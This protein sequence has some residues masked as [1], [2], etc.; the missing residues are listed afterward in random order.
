MLS[1]NTTKFK[2][3]ILY[4]SFCYNLLDINGMHL[5]CHLDCSRKLNFEK[6]IFS[7]KYLHL[8]N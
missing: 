3:Y 8:D 7:K 6:N 5:L 4:I 2:K 1:N